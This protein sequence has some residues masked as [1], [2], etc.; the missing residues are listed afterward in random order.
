MY[1]ATLV[2]RIVFDDQAATRATLDNRKTA[3]QER[4]PRVRNG[5]FLR[6]TYLSLTLIDINDVPSEASSG[7]R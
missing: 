6:G 1:N 2:V 3:A 5:A 4:T 7:I